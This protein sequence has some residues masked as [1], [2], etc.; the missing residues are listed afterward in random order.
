[1]TTSVKIMIEAYASKTPM[2][3]NQFVAKMLGIVE[4]DE[5]DAGSEDL[6]IQV[7]IHFRIL[8][9]VTQLHVLKMWGA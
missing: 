8:V 6:Q 2:H 4:L 9:F 5:T 7:M 3:Y 1:M